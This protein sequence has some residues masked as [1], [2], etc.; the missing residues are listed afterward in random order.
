M[1]DFSLTLYVSL[2]SVGL[3]LFSQRFLLDINSDIKASENPLT[4]PYVEM[5]SL[6]IIK[7]TH[8]VV[9]LLYNLSIK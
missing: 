2:K 8:F 4:M 9:L 1:I 5:K 6:K 3:S 7:G